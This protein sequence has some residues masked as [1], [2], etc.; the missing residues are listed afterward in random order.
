MTKLQWRRLLAPASLVLAVAAGL[1]AGYIAWGWPTN[2]YA[3]HDLAKLPPGPQSDLIRYGWELIVQTPRHIGRS[4]TDPARRYAGNDLRCSH[5][6]IN[7][8]L[9]PFAAPM[10]STFASFPMSVDDRVLTLNERINGCM[11]RSMNGSPMP[12]DGR[13]MEA[14]IAYIRFI[15]TGSPQG[16]RIAGMGVKPLRPAA[17]TPDRAR[18]QEVYAGRCAKCHMA[19]GQG[20]P[21]APPGVGYAVPPL[22]GDASFNS[23]AGMA[24]IETAAAFIHVNMPIGATYREPLLTEQQAWDVAAFITSQPRPHPRAATASPRR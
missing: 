12:D 8:A 17:R 3:G 4:A 7:S 22:W 9:K 5:C 23:A 21:Y 16:V 2:Y 24:R 14:L 19:E 1:G 11:T 18:G 15:G 6:H 20:E 13:E 10:V